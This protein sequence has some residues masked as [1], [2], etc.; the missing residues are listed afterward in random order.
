LSKVE[1]Q[2][3]LKVG[4]NV[5]VNVVNVKRIR[6]RENAKITCEWRVVVRNTKTG[7]ILQEIKKRN[8][9]TNG[10]LGVFATRV[11]GPWSTHYWCLALG[12]GAGTPS[13]TDTGLFTEVAASRKS[14]SVSKP[15]ANQVQYWVRYLPEEANGYT[16]TEAGI[17]EDTASDLTGGTLINHLMLSPTLEKTSDILVDF[18][19]T[20]TFS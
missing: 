14:G 19:T 3:T 15:A 8:V 1:K 6:Q 18:Y 4:D 9:I 17:F 10:G 11:K 20:I 12:T 16:Y 2:E 13:A 7:K 5:K